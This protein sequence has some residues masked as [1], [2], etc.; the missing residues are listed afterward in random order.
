MALPPWQ[1]RI[2]SKGAYTAPDGV[3]RLEFFYGN[4]SREFD[5]KGSAFDFPLADETYVQPLGRTGFRYPLRLIFW[6]GTCDIQASAFEDLLSQNGIGK[7]EHPLYGTMDVIPMGTIKRTDDLVSAANQSVIEVTFWQTTGAV[8]PG[9]QLDPASAIAARLL[10]FNAALAAQTLEQAAF[11]SAYES[12][13]GK[14]AFSTL[15]D[16]VTSGL[17]AVA[18]KQAEVAKRFDTITDSINRGIDVLIRD[19]LTLANQTLLMIQT[20]AR[21]ASGIRARLEAYGN[22]ANSI[23]SQATKV[24]S[25]TLDSVVENDLVLNTLY[26]NGYVSGAV[27]SAVN[28]TFT[29]KPEALSAAAEISEMFEAAT[30]YLDENRDSL[31]VI[32]TG[33]TYQNL[34]E[35]VGLV[36]GFLVDISFNLKQERI[37]NLPRDR[38]PVDLCGELYG[39][40][41]TDLDFFITSNK[42]VGDQFF[43]IK[44]GTEIKYY[45]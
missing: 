9:N 27:V 11:D 25:N 22:L 13:T 2:K 31:S 21:A 24:P 1:G 35:M 6:G 39:N 40:V 34:Q 29:T 44:K 30:V 20:P 38:S 15:L 32:D 18:D 10:L 43:E 19:P 41:D 17:R 23:T 12:A 14:T 28:H 37:I 42:L 7:L 3:S 16:S 8:Y 26:L 45:V 36:L 33:E 4:V 5:K